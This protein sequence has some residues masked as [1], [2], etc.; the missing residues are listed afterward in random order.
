MGILFFV[1]TFNNLH[2]P[3]LV[4]AD[5]RDFPL[6]FVNKRAKLMLN[7]MLTVNA[8]RKREPEPNRLA[9]LLRFQ[10][11]ET[12]VDLFKSINAH[13]S[14]SDFRTN[15]LSYDGDT[16]PISISA[17]K[18]KLEDDHYHVIY[19]YEYAQGE[20]LTKADADS[21]LANAFYMTFHTINVDESINRVLALAGSHVG[22]SRAYIFEEVSATMTRN[23]YEWCA[24]GVP[25]AIQ[26][27]QNLKK[28]DYNYDAIVT[29]GVYV[30][31]DIRELPDVDREI[32]AAQ[33]IRSLAILPLYNDGKPLGYVGFDDCEKYRKWGRYEIYLLD[34]ISSILVSL[35]LRRNA[36]SQAFRSL[37]ILRTIT[38]SIDNVIY[39]N[40]LDTYEL[41]FVNRTLADDIGLEAE[42]IVGM[43]CWEVLQ[44][45]QAGP[46]AF[47]P[48]K[49]MLNKDG[50]V[51]RDNYVWEHWN[52]NTGRWYLIRDTII[53]W[54]DGELVHLE[55]ATEITHQKKTEEELKYSASI[56]AMTGAYNREWG[57]KFLE[58]KRHAAL[59]AKEELSLCFIDLD[60]LKYVND[61]FGHDAGDEMILET[62][63]VI[64]SGVR[65]S[66]TICRWGGDEFILLLEC[67]VDVA[68]RV[69]AKIARAIEQ[70]NQDSSRSYKLSFSYGIVDFCSKP[71]A[72]VEEVVAIADR[73][74]Y[75]NKIGKRR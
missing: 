16:L 70:L 5:G 22:V 66:D 34:N 27:L 10:H 57:R 72:P 73:L 33:G 4:C 50:S 26:D 8:L 55:T 7:P 59:Q 43:P 3:V 48:M 11:S 39:A 9:D 12:Y 74:M 21:I 58:Q 67:P 62:L 14:V 30:T 56:D 36:E 32:L 2:I 28:E 40:A 13:G 52:T 69:L 65:K 42:N 60:G 25:P 47:C 63:G 35:I 29:S 75:D 18:V 44:K 68:H 19:I 49:I 38:D 53:K 17:N 71:D 31:D 24:E 20:S 45:S 54:I 41:I 1:N 37:E 6:V 51:L 64:R 15:I 23:T 46:C 61:T